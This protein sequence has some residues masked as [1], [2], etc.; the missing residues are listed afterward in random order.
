MPARAPVSKANRESDLSAILSF[1]ALPPSETKRALVLRACEH[2]LKKK[3]PERDFSFLDRNF[4]ERYDQAAL[5]QQL[6]YMMRYQPDM[7]FDYY[8]NEDALLIALYFKNPPGRLLRR[9]WSHPLRVLPD[10]NTC[11]TFVKHDQSA[12]FES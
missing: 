3:E 1:S 12:R 2:M 4:V 9:Q 8:P 11:R 5:R 6:S 7:A 10:F